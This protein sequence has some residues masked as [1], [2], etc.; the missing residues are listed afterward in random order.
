MLSIPVFSNYNELTFGVNMFKNRHSSV[1]ITL[2]DP[3]KSCGHTE[4]NAV[5]FLTPDHWGN[6]C[7][8]LNVK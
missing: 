6:G 3:R 8:D 7:G 2:L 1:P 4:P 5:A